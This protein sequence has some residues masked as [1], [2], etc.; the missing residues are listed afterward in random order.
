MSSE[1]IQRDEKASL[2]HTPFLGIVIYYTEQLIPGLRQSNDWE[3]L[4]LD[5]V[6][7]VVLV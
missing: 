3:F 5:V 2:S 4:V 7:F 1:I 6:L